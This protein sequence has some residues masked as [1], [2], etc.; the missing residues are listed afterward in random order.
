MKKISVLLVS[1]LMVLLVAVVSAAPSTYSS[2]FQIANMSGTDAN[3]VITYVKQDGSV[4]ATV[5]DMIP[6][7]G[8]IT[9]FPIDANGGFNGS[10]VVSSDQPV[11]A[12]ANVL[13]DGF[14]YG[15]S[16]ESFDAGAATVSLP[17]IA[18]ANGGY[19]TWFNV[20]NTS[21]PASGADV[22][23]D[24]SF[25]EVSCD[26]T[27]VVIKAGA[28]HT[29]DQATN[30][31]LGAKY[32][33]A[34]T[35]TATGGT[36]V[37]VVMQTG[38]ATLLAYNGF[39]SGSTNPIM[40]LVQANNAGYSTGI[41]IQNM[42]A[43][44]TDVTVSYVAGDAGTDCNEMKTIAGGTSE[45][46]ALWATCTA[47]FGGG[48]PKFIG[49]A[50]V[51]GN[52]GSEDLVAIVNQVN[53]TTN[54]KGA[55]YDAFDPADASASVNFPLIM[56]DNSGY[57]TGFNIYNAGAADA[58][59]TCTFS[60][61]A[62]NPGNTPSDVVVILGNGESYTALQMGTGSYVGGVVCT[63]AGGSL[64]GVTNELGS[65]AGDTLFAYNGFNQ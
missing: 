28:A 34:A 7:N 1:A 20:Q 32:V 62:D 44:S 49:A 27:G 21:D 13:G 23:V 26:E 64:V 10:V 19:D 35:V 25:S 52:T 39:A 5:D 63:A 17:L 37:A 43:A 53:F 42:G 2:G 58:A 31:C 50:S 6:A 45:T 14:A 36:I 48:N 30:T 9:Y 40:P 3:V 61:D 47:A 15:A 57:F 8:S 4:D 18:K 33:G 11:A 41:Q 46:F 65:G 16:Y 56:Q 38:P 29:F 59:V 54:D 60:T 51:T 12:I 22:T 55:A 24:V